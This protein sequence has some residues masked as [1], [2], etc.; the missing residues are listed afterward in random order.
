MITWELHYKTWGESEAYS[1][2]PFEGSPQHTLQN[3]Q[4]TLQM[5]ASAFLKP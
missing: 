2:P 1:H 3:S 5:S 4:P